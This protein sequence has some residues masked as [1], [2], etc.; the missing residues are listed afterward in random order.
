MK[1]QSSLTDRSYK[2]RSI[3]L[4]LL[5]R[6]FNDMFEDVIQAPKSSQRQERPALLFNPVVSPIPGF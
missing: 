1:F 3:L 2:D 4:L 6:S 5:S